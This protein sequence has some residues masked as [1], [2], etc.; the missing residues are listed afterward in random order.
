MN[1][2]SF[3]KTFLIFIILS[4]RV[5]QKHWIVQIT[6]CLTGR[7]EVRSEDFRQFLMLSFCSEH[8]LLT[9]IITVFR[10]LAMVVGKTLGMKQKEVR[11]HGP[12]KRTW[13]STMQHQMVSKVLSY[14]CHILDILTLKQLNIILLSSFFFQ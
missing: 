9:K 11:R 14:L 4:I 13:L 1:L 6:H 7:L 3:T 12:S 8:N 10:R 5:F 2:A